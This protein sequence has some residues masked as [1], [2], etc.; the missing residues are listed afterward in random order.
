MS[1]V[2]FYQFEGQD[3]KS[4]GSIIFTSFSAFYRSVGRRYL[5]LKTK[6][7]NLVLVSFPSF[8]LTLA[9][10]WIRDGQ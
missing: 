10:N 6:L 2:G 7:Q 5:T 3:L 4:L 9:L 8:L 1:S